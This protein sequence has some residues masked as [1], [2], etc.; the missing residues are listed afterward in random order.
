MKS[1]PEIRKIA[2]LLIPFIIAAPSPILADTVPD[3]MGRHLSEAESISEA[4]G[5]VLQ[6]QKIDSTTTRDEVLLQIPAAGSKIGT[7]RR[8]YIQVSNGVLV[9]DLRGLTKSQ[10][11]T[12]LKDLGIHFEVTYRP[13]TGV[14]NNLLAAHIPKAGE[15]LDVAR[16]TV[17]LIM[18]RGTITIPSLVDV[19]H[20]EA[21]ARLTH[22]N[23][24][25]LLE[26]PFHSSDWG[27]CWKKHYSSRVTRTDPSEGALVEPRQQV[28]LY[29]ERV[30]IK[31]EHSRIFC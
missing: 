9:P 13:W 17:F 16:Q 14:R 2:I 30:L 23:L 6:V 1:L 3:L 26:R 12:I 20:E 19:F 31:E 10:A 28:T 22:L 25:G 29:Y 27:Y 24:I 7:A 21:I 4:E 15:R 11:E 8:I 5:F 18:S